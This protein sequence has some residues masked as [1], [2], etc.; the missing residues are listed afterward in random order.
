MAQDVKLMYEPN[1]NQARATVSINATIVATYEAALGTD[2]KFGDVIPDD[3]PKKVEITPYG[4]RKVSTGGNVKDIK[5]Q[6]VAEDNSK[7]IIKNSAG[8]PKPILLVKESSNKKQTASDMIIVNSRG[9]SPARYY[10]SGGDI[11]CKII[12]PDK[13]VV[14][15]NVSQSARVIVSDWDARLFSDNG[16]ASQS[17]IMGATLSVGSKEQTPP[18]VYEGSYNITF[19]YN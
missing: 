13:P 11:S 18:G 7:T 17:L 1:F 5:Y 6:D 4:G 12:L 8:G 15:S 3:K 16:G 2:L 19:L 14:L 9:Y 10:V